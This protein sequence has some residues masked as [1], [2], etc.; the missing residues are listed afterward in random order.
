MKL[1]L[2]VSSAAI[3]AACGGGDEGLERRFQLTATADVWENHMPQVLMPGEA[4]GCIPLMVWF[5][6]SAQKGHLPTDLTV[7]VVTLKK[8][9]NAVWQTPP[10]ASE[11]KLTSTTTYSGVARGCRTAALA[12]GEIVDV[13]LTVRSAEATAQVHTSSRLGYAS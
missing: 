1:L 8:G 7:E 10:S 11:S 5:T 2:L 9:A 12:E 13:S 3:L 4:P 6:V